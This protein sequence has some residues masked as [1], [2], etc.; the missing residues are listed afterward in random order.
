ME[1]MIIISSST[2]L[3]L[4]M[5]TWKFKKWKNFLINN[6]S[7]LIVS[8]FC[9]TKYIIKTDFLLYFKRLNK[10]PKFVTFSEKKKSKK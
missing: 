10:I 8:V 1:M 9:N 4:Y 3:S 7:T 5:N 2:D 6:I